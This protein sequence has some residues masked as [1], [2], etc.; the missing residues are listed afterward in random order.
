MDWSNV[1]VVSWDLDGTLYETAPLWGAFRTLVWKPLRPGS[2]IRT[3]RELLLLR[4]YRRWIASARL[5]GG[6]LGEVPDA[7]QGPEADAVIDRWLSGAIRRSG[8]AVGVSEFIQF[9]AARGIRQVVCTDLRCLGKVDALAL[10]Q[11]F[12]AIIEGER[13]GVIKPHHQLLQSVLEQTGVRSSA[14]VHIGDRE[15][16]DRP[17]AEAVGVKCLILG[18]DFEDYRCL[19]RTLP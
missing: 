14:V 15:D 1:E 6:V 16:T 9:L 13:L 11:G 4:R 2:F 7:L 3:L 5:R 8:A 19:M 10:P 18:T 12:E 17:A